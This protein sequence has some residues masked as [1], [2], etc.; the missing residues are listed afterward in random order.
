MKLGRMQDA[1]CRMHTEARSDPHGLVAVGLDDAPAHCATTVFGNGRHRGLCLE[2]SNEAALV[3]PP[4]DG[5]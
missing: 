3:V 5:T 4:F 2:M 1:G